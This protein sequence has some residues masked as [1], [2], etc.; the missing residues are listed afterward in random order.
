MAWL[1]L[2]PDPGAEWAAQASPP[3]CIACGEAGVAD[4][5]LNVL[6]FVPL[7]MAL[8]RLRWAGWAVAAAGLG[9]SAV[10]EATQGL[11]LVGRDATLG[12]LLAN[13]AGAAIGFG[14]MGRWDRRSRRAQRTAAGALLAFTA[15][16]ALSG[17]LLEPRLA[18]PEPWHTRGPGEF[19]G[20]PRYPGAV[21]D[22]ALSR[23][24]LLSVSTA[25]RGDSA[26]TMRVVFEWRAIEG[27]P[28]V[29]V[30]DANGRALAA[31]GAALEK[32][33]VS[34]AVRG[35]AWRLRTP[36][37]Q[38]PL[39]AAAG[40]TVTVAMQGVRGTTTI[41]STTPAGTARHV[42]RVGPQHGWLLL[43]P[44]A[45]G[46]SGPAWLVYAVLWMGGWGAVL[47]LAA[48]EARHRWRWLV[49][50]AVVLIG[51]TAVAGTVVSWVELLALAC[52]WWAGISAGRLHP[53]PGE[54]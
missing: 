51:I 27:A 53:P 42:A 23:E 1:T 24:A 19:E 2:R 54:A 40:D 34:L 14:T 31:L 35:S 9:L 39:A 17:W 38:V 47:G 11:V 15:M 30:E 45:P 29:R 21:L 6:L 26:A 52:G 20:R 44:F 4:L 8:R 5:L 48:T 13:T 25:A 28:V 18:G 12:D 7:G 36:S 33:A 41:E 37:W 46:W 32:V 43:N 22:A 50:A 16:L 49:A 10:I 3:G